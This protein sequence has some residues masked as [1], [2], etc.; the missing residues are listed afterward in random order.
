VNEVR[1]QDGKHQTYSRLFDL[2]SDKAY[3]VITSNADGMFLR[4]GF[5]EDLF[6]SPQGDYANMQC[7]KPCNN[8]VW[9]TKPVIDRIVPTVDPATAEVTDPRVIPECPCCG[10]PVFLNVRGGSWFIEDPY[11]EQAERFVEWV[12][13]SAESNLVVI[14]IGAGFNTPGVIRWRME[15]I[16]HA[17]PSAHLVRV[18]P[19]FPEVPREI[20]HKSVSLRCGAM[21]ATSAILQGMG[22]R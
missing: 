19:Q 3:F 2:V 9:E 12:R 14:E 13:R 10:G 5:A 15:Q 8:A 4:N 22:L 21:T 11:L 7:L 18:N 16:V 1:F 6:F 20:A 17:H